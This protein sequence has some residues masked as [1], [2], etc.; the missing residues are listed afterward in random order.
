MLKYFFITKLYHIE[1]NKVMNRGIPTIGN[2]RLSI[3]KERLNKMLDGP[4][5]EMV[6]MLEYE[7][8]F[9]GCY[10]YHEGTLPNDFDADNVEKRQA[11]LAEFLAETQIFCNTLWLIKDNGVH[12]ENGYL[13]IKYPNGL[14]HSV[15]SN[16]RSAMFSCACSDNKLTTFTTEEINKVIQFHNSIFD[17]TFT[18]GKGHQEVTHLVNTVSDRLERF[19]Y[20]LQATRRETHLPS[21]IAMY[22]TLLETLLSTETTEITH[23][24]SERAARLLGNTF[25]ERNEIF[26]FIKKAYSIRS[27]TVHGDKISK[28]LR[29]IEI[30]KEIS[31]QFDEY[32]RRLFLLIVQSEEMCS[33]F[34][35]DNNEK[36]NNWFNKL[37]LS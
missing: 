29:N 26:S 19:I 7:A 28:K 12:V 15:S 13:Y 17:N 8:L 23:K 1:I 27:S 20:F 37:V 6:G 16:M 11:F 14:F 31:I 25:E 2:L 3:S 18:I 21:K 32:M 35:E 30:Q 24:I 9:E 5:E 22:C 10:L 36:I 4:F 34:K 33:I